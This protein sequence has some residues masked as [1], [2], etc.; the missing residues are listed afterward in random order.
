MSKCRVIFR[1]LLLFALFLVFAKNAFERSL[2]HI[3]EE[4]PSP[5]KKFDVHKLDQNFIEQIEEI[6]NQID[7]AYAVAQIRVEKTGTAK[8]I[9]KEILKK[10]EIMKH[11][12]QQIEKRYKKNSPATFL[13]GPLGTTSIV[14]KEREL[15]KQL[16]KSVSDLGEILYTLQ[17][18]EHKEI[19]VASIEQAIAINNKIIAEIT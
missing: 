4:K 10:L 13:L 2:E 16:H 18:N 7:C 14:M 3:K 9:F 11:E 5:W 6:K 12:V 19:E 8:E 15:E 1:D 17:G